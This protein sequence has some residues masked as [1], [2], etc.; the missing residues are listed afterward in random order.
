MRKEHL[1]SALV[2]ART[3]YREGNIQ[4]AIV[5]LEN[6]LLERKLCKSNKE[7]SLGCQSMAVLKTLRQ[8]L[9]QQMVAGGTPRFSQSVLVEKPIW[10]DQSSKDQVRSR[11]VFVLHLKGSLEKL[12]K[13]REET[14]LLFLDMEKSEEASLPTL[15]TSVN[16]LNNKQCYTL[17]RLGVLERRY[18][19]AMTALRG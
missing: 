17:R 3:L 15:N 13:L 1:K 5:V 10:S 7:D 19:Y 18:R 6:A 16:R 14:R 8:Q 2:E 9:E 11:N 4:R 12:E